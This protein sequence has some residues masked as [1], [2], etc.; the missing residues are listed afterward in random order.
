MLPSTTP[1]P[2]AVALLTPSALSTSTNVS[3]TR[4][5]G[6]DLLRGLCAIAVALYHA[7]SWL[8]VTHLDAWGRYGVYVFFVLSGASMYIAYDEKFQRGYAPV[9][10]IALRFVRLA[11]LY[12]AA[13]SI[14][15]A[16][17]IVIGRDLFDELSMAL[18]NVTFSFGMGNPAET[19]R[20]I[21]GWS[22]GIEFMFYLMF[23]VVTAVARGKAC[24]YA[25]AGAFVCQH[26]F[27]NHVLA[28]S[29]L[30]RS[31]IAYTQLLSFIFYFVAG[32]AI[33]RVVKARRLPQSPWVALC[34][35]ILLIAL[36]SFHGES[37]L[38]G[39]T[40]L[41]LSLCAVALVFA[42]SAL[43]LKGWL[44]TIADLLGKMS[45]GVYLIHPFIFMACKSWLLLSYPVLSALLIVGVSAALA[46]VAERYLETPI[47]R[48]AQSRL[49]K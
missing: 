27:I 41:A 30:E 19:S 44:V 32:C 36:S 12:L 34:F 5:H 22:L 13:L 7:L 49:Q 24:W 4:V 31:W 15:L 35:G 2:A 16:Y 29:T 37:N 14:K 48:L 10:F 46:L 1:N 25:V 38:T 33:G 6:F 42:S 9:K 45:Y 3:A 28:D 40:G 39:V 17:A 26:V 47:M 23:P 43:V 18:L 8:G 11:P 21:G 20:V